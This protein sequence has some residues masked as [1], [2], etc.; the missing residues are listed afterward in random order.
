MN[1][2]MRYS[3]DQSHVCAAAQSF[4]LYKYCLLCIWGTIVHSESYIAPKAQTVSTSPALPYQID[5][6]AGK[7]TVAAGVRVG[8]NET[9]LNRKGLKFNV[10]NK[11][12][13]R[14]INYE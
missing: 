4:Q 5:L 12:N 7:W 9:N 6:Q 1:L 14:I 10:M 11:T 3:P 2:Y 8:M 13:G